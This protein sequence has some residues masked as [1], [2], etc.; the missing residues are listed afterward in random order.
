M[1][2]SLSNLSINQFINTKRKT[3]T[4]VKRLLGPRSFACN[5]PQRTRTKHFYKICTKKQNKEKTKKQEQ[6]KKTLEQDKDI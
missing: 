3:I 2:T 1:R 6:K 5:G 4:K